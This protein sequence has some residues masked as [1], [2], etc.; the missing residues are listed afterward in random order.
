[1]ELMNSQSLSRT[2]DQRHI[3]GSA[4]ISDEIEKSRQGMLQM[5][6][7][8]TGENYLDEWAPAMRR[9]LK[10]CSLWDCIQPKTLDDKVPSDQRKMDMIGA[11]MKS[12]FAD[13]MTFH[14]SLFTEH[15]D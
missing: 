7:R 2:E 3:Y 14:C 5:V 15:A 12:T 13:D 9:Y 1:M 10:Y 6:P 8:L 4:D 11:H